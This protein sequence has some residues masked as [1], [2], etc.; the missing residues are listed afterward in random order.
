MHLDESAARQP[1][2]EDAELVWLA[3]RDDP[4]AWEALVRLH[5]VPVFHLA[6]LILG[7]AAEAEDAAQE[8]F[9]RV[10]TALNRFDETRPLRPWLLSIAAKLAGDETRRSLTVLPAAP[11]LNARDLSGAALGKAS[12]PAVIG[13][14]TLVIA[15]G[16]LPWLTARLDSGAESETAQ[17]R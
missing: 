9:I 6:Y 13:L 4:A 12:V 7:D 10:Y 8:T 1:A 17:I 11:A 14:A 16:A 3:R 2:A 5:Q 15:L